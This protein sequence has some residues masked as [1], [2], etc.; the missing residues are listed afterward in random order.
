V[1]HGHF[2]FSV[3]IEHTQGHALCWGAALKLTPYQ[4]CAG[5]S[6]TPNQINIAALNVLDDTVSDTE[7]HA[8]DND[9]VVMSKRKKEQLAENQRRH[10]NKYAIETELD[11]NTIEE[12]DTTGRIEIS[13]KVLLRCVISHIRRTLMW[14]HYPCMRPVSIRTLSLH[15]VCCLPLSTICT[16]GHGVA[17]N[18][19]SA[20]TCLC[21]S[22][23]GLQTW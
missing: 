17:C 10:E 11:V 23:T 20:H 21:L 16:S 6:P 7:S 14:R 15:H 1:R 19:I 9:D 13:G 3:S 8:A 4:M 22:R 18:L 5:I 2:E 12:L